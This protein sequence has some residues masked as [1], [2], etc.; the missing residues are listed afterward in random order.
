[1][2]GALPADKVGAVK[3]AEGTPEPAAL[4]AMMQKS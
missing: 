3:M 1:M 2:S 4:V